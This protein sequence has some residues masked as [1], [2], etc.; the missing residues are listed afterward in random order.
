MTGVVVAH[1]FG[2][3]ISVFISPHGIG[4]STAFYSHFKH[5]VNQVINILILIC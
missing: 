3:N 1:G 5:A 4:F 2:D